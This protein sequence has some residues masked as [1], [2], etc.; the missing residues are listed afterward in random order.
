[1]RFLFEMIDSQYVEWLSRA[2]VK[3]K[4]LRCD[5]DYASMKFKT[6][7]GLA[8]TNIYKKDKMFS[9]YKHKKLSITI[10]D[11]HLNPFNY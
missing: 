2:N 9:D 11:T 8:F 6:Y 3:E 1:M 4:L 5:S 10:C 7:S